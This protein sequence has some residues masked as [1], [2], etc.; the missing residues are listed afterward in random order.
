MKRETVVIGLA[1]VVVL[2][3]GVAEF[4]EKLQAS[5]GG[6]QSVAAPV[7]GSSVPIPLQLAALD[8]NAGVPLGAETSYRTALRRLTDSCRENEREIAEMAISA[9][10]EIRANTGRRFMVL[11]VLEQAALVAPAAGPRSECLVTFQVIRDNP[12]PR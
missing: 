7:L 12:L 9:S 6:S 10:R 4:S 1:V 5:A 11:D 3:A 8:H 2:V